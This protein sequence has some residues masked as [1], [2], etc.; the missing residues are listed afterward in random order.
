MNRWQKRLQ[1]RKAIR[2]RPLQA[3]I[4]RNPFIA[5]T[6]NSNPIFGDFSPPDYNVN[7]KLLTLGTVAPRFRDDSEM[8][9]T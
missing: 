7:Q 1:M 3:R 6:H 2:P 5:I 8:V 4:T 9:L